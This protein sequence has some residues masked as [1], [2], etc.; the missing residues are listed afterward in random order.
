MQ[1]NDTPKIETPN[2]EIKVINT[3]KNVKDGQYK[4]PNCGASQITFN[5]KTGKLKCNYCQQ[6]FDGNKLDNVIQDVSKLQGKVVGKGAT[7]IKADAKNII[8]LKC[9]GCGAEVVIDMNDA[10]H[11]RCHWCRSILSINAQVENG[12]IPDVILPF[13]IKKEEAKEKITAFV[14]ERRFFAHPK[15]KKEFT[16]DNII[17][18]Y[19]PYLIIDANAHANFEGEGE[20]LIRHYYVGSGDNRESRYDADLYKVSRDFDIGI[21]DLTIESNKE[22]LDKKDESK[23]NNII[24]SIMPFD[25]ENV[26]EYQS[27]YLI[28]FNSEKRDV[29]ISDIEEKVNKQIKD[30]SRHG[31]NKDLSFYDRGI[32]WDKEDVNVKGTQ[33]LAAYLPVWLYSYMEEKKGKK[34]IHYVAVNART[35]ETMGSVPINFRRLILISTL[36]E[37][38]CVFLTIFL[39]F[40]TTGSD[41]DSGGLIFLL[42]VGGFAF[43]GAMYLRYRNK[44]ARHKYEKDTNYKIENIQR[45]DE[46]KENLHGLHNAAMADANN[47]KIEGDII[48][49]SYLNTFNNIKIK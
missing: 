11:A 35:K 19:F 18:V 24:N 30:I 38:L 49:K 33:W 41:D 21:D 34:L 8:T 40:A 42:L 26:I 15:F 46:L 45:T 47:N 12:T 14:K 27:N 17:G 13:Q 25:T 1:D 23:T 2:E 22:K 36:I 29:N 28:G 4:C 20:H 37:I 7:N 44:N 39:L 10:P 16:T 6:E 32:R 48:D 3:K 5:E 43:Y 9:G 31:I